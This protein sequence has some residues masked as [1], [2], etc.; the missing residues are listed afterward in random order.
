MDDGGKKENEPKYRIGALNLRNHQRGVYPHF[1]A[2]VLVIRT[3]LG[4][5]PIQNDTDQVR[6]E[7]EPQGLVHFGF[8]SHALP[9]D[10][11]DAIESRQDRKGVVR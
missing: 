8:L 3:H 2:S 1:V 4:P 6:T 9:H 7:L 10:H 11:E 5:R